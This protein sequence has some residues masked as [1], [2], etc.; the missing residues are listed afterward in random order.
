MSTIPLPAVSKTIRVDVPVEE[1]F[2]TFTRRIDAWWPMKTHSRFG[3]AA[4]AVVLEER[5]GGRVF[6]RGPGGEEWDWAD[7][8]E[9]QP[10]SRVLLR[11]RVN[12]ERG[13]TEIEVTF[14]AE[15]D[16]TRVDLEHR[17]WDRIGDEEGRS[18]YDAGWTVVL[19]TY[20]AFTRPS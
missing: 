10:S 2:D 15:G 13:A 3:A 8:L 14:T 4:T 6:E 12:P 7:V 17:G 11:W 19:E 1:A 20:R 5:A 18:D 16:G 9:F